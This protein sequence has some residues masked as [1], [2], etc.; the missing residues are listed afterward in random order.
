LLYFFTLPIK[1]LIRRSCK[2]P[3]QIPFRT[4]YSALHHQHA[5]RQETGPFLLPAAEPQQQEHEQF[6]LGHPHHRGLRGTHEQHQYKFR[7]E[8]SQAHPRRYAG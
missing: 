2:R 1:N 5:L 8:G 7:R 4:N 6:E 3:L